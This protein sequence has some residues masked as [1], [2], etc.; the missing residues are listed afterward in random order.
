MKN[1]L[2]DIL[3]DRNIYILTVVAFILAMI[4]GFIKK[5]FYLN[6][7][8]G[9]SIIGMIYFAIGVFRWSWKE[10]DYT[11]FSYRPKHGSFIQWKA[12]R[13]DERR[14]AKNPFLP[15]SIIVI[16]ISLILT[17]FY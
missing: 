13:I 15:A 8:N 16:I 10:G 2:I 7:I 6:F 12:G 5:P 14:Y 11:F 4:Y 1:K 3:K 17:L 9:I